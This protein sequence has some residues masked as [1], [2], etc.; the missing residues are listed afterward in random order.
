MSLFTHFENKGGEIMKLR[1]VS[2]L[3][4]VLF[5]IV[6]ANISITCAFGLYEPELPD[7]LR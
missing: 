1:M 2:L 5:L 3:S 6:Q 7:C 4:T